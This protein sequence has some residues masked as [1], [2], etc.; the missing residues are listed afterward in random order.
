MGKREEDP[1]KEVRAVGKREEDSGKE[2][3][4]WEGGEYPWEGEETSVGTSF[5]G[6]PYFAS[7]ILMFCRLSAHLFQTTNP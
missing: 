5:E 6:R 1:G 3:R 7:L 4:T 2:G